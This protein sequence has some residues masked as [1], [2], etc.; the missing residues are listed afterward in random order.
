MKME[1][2]HLHVHSE[3]SFLDGYCRL[4]ELIKGAKAKSIKALALTDHFNMSGA[5]PFYQLAR[6][7][8]VKPI[9]GVEIVLEPPGYFHLVLLAKNNQGYVHLME[10]VTRALMQRE[11]NPHVKWEELREKSPGLV[12]LS[13]CRRGEIPHLLLAGKN[14]LAQNRARAYRNLFGQRNFYLEI[15]ASFPALLQKRI[16]HLSRDSG[17]PV[18]GTNN[19]HYVEREE[20]K[21]HEQFL[22]LQ[23]ISRGSY[24]AHDKGQ[25][26]LNAAE[27]QESFKSYPEA[28]RNAEEIAE[29][30]N[31]TLDLYDLHLPSLDL[32]GGVTPETALEKLARS[33]HTAPGRDYAE[34]L[35]RELD[36]I[37]RTGFAGY[38]LIVH[39][40]VSFCMEQNIPVTARGSAVGSYVGYLLG[41]GT[42]DPVANNLYFERFLNPERASSP[43]IDL[44]ISHTGRKKVLEYLYDKYGEGK[45]AHIG[46]FSTFA[47]RAAVH[48]AAKA[49]GLDEEE[50]SYYSSLVRSS[51]LPLGQSMELVA[52]ANALPRDGHSIQEVLNLAGSLLGRTRHLTQHSSGVV[53]AP[54]GLTNY[55]ALQYSRDG[56]I[57]TQ[58]DMH[59]IE[60]LG[61]LKIDLL[62]S[63]FQSAIQL[64][65]SEVKAGRSLEVKGRSLPVDDP[66][67]YEM[68]GRGHSMGVFQLESTGTRILMRRMKPRDL[69][70]LIAATSLYRPGPLKS[71]MAENYLQRRQRGEQGDPPH[72]AL[73]E[74][75]KDSLGT[76]IWQEQ[77]METARVLAG[78]SLG[79]ADILRRAMSKKNPADMAGEK[80]EF[81]S[82]SR[83]RGIDRDQAEEIF[84]LLSHFS[85]YCFNKA[86]AAAYAQ[87]IYQTAYLKNY[88]PLEYM[89]ALFNSHW[90]DHGRISKYLLECRRMNIK[91]LGININHSHSFFSLEGKKLRLGLAAVKN[92]G[93]KGVQSILA[94]REKGIFNSFDDFLHRIQSSRALSVSAI[95]SLIKCGA[96][97]EFGHC[98][99]LLWKLPGSVKLHRAGSSRR[100]SPLVMDGNGWGWGENWGKISLTRQ[101]RWEYEHLGYFISGNPLDI[102]EEFDSNKNVSINFIFSQQQVNSFRIAGLVTLIRVRRKDNGS[103]IYLVEVED[104]EGN[105]EFYARPRQGWDARVGDLVEVEIFCPA[106]EN[107]YQLFLKKLLRKRCLRSV[108]GIT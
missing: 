79:Q 71:G 3:F 26:L 102:I 4:E 55:T 20:E 9:F 14:N 64:T 73:R 82:R 75:L 94:E 37:K 67:T 53:L 23:K 44:D 38:F 107:S 6:S 21:E 31:V 60:D 95:E 40:I 84:D 27:M 93:I 8:G 106:R 105:V 5:V 28:L 16:I 50:A 36:I 35:Q 70:D 63:R 2:C 77:V 88:F 32:E 51:Y 30:C 92:I 76:I 81:I 7:T 83:E 25:H 18:V 49:L 45:I 52:K 43:D 41:M 100:R 103:P 13:G 48:D 65:Q 104:R 85:S 108:L 101:L 61:L 58:L 89:V 78:Y 1:I 80:N 98:Y 54:E 17:L 99:D 87:L 12:A 72:P 19:V 11:D 62:G 39:D 69:K 22:V 97:S 86:H 56:E 42:V 74:V 15:A 90:G 96:F 29:R 68:L 10:L 24:P 91:I 66:K 33:Y 46:A 59:G 47:G 34:R 57:I